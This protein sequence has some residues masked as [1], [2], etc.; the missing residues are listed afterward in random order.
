MMVNTALLLAALFDVSSLVSLFAG[1][2]R[3]FGRWM[4]EWTCNAKT[5]ISAETAASFR[6]GTIM[7]FVGREM[8][9]PFLPGAQRSGE[10]WAEEASQ[11]YETGLR[12]ICEYDSLRYLDGRNCAR[13][14][15]L[16]SSGCR[17]P[18]V[19]M[20]SAFD[21][22]LNW[23]D[24]RDAC[25]AR[26]E[27]AE[28]MVP[29]GRDASFVRLLARF[30]RYRIRR[31]SFEEVKALF[32]EWLGSRG[33]GNDDE[34]AI[35]NIH[36]NF[37]GM[38][39]GVL[40]SFPY[41]SWAS[42][43]ETAKEGL[44]EARREAGN[45]IAASVSQKGWNMLADRYRSALEILD[46]AER[47]R[48]D[49]VETLYSRLWIDGESRMGDLK[50]RQKLFDEISRRR[51]D[52]PAAI[53]E[54]VWHN[55]YPRWGAD[56]QRRMMRR[57]A[58][59][60]YE[61]GRHDT[62]LPY[63]YAE[64]MCRYVRDSAI[65]PFSY[66][67]A[68]ADVAEKCIDVC[69]RQ[70][71]NEFA[72]GY[73]RGRAPFVGAAVAVYAGMYEKA[74]EFC[75]YIFFL[76]GDLDEIFF[77]KDSLAAAID[78][79]AGEYSQF[80]LRLQ[81]LYD[82]G[83]YQEFLEA[84]G[85]MMPDALKENRW[86]WQHVRTLMYGVAMKTAFEQ[87][88]DVDAEIP[89][90]FPGWW[91]TGWWRADDRTWHTYWDFEWKHH[92]TWRA[93][94]PKNHEL[95]LVFSPKPDTGGRHVLVVSRC[96]YE[97]THHLP[98]NKIPFATFIWEE[99]R[100]GVYLGNDYYGMISVDPARAVWKPA[101]DAPRNVRI[102]CDGGRVDVFIE[103]ALVLSTRDHAGA[104]RRSPDTGYIRFH[105]ENASISGIVVR[106]PRTHESGAGTP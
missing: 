24:N 93:Q 14:G 97:E 69:M 40:E 85:K 39:V 49:R 98:I 43:I 22:E 5:N 90:C 46:E 105:G 6:D 79:F 48:P 102:V 104:M 2:E 53:R 35:Y 45:G 52:Y 73:V 7:P 64:T 80:C 77:D 82:E 11:V 67:R 1:P 30:M 13:A 62:A 28:S 94:I 4:A 41:L 75:P 76:P 38:N 78:A 58:D 106:K 65:D 34:V 31:C 15:R 61:T 57:F 9:D 23:L 32:A 83:K 51:L 16:Y 17:E 71:T 47:L 72:C 8:P 68:H 29:Q 60:C 95:E 25:A 86:A 88:M 92:V 33:F 21:P 27:E 56:R 81:R 3:E 70:T 74:A 101:R 66:F 89:A 100:T 91:N 37:F 26:L 54:F 63:F 42:M 19:T 50:T 96:V 44:Q 36:R 84:T 20:L 18:F 103:G 12:D 10:T 87:G 59:A 55:L 99:E